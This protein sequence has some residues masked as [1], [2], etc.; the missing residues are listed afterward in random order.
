MYV[1]MFQYSNGTPG[2]I[3]TKFGTHDYICIYTDHPFLASNPDWEMNCELYELPPQKEIAHDINLRVALVGLIYG[4]NTIQK[5]NTPAWNLS[6]ADKPV[7][8][9]T[10]TELQRLFYKR[11]TEDNSNTKLETFESK[12]CNL[13]S[14]LLPFGAFPDCLSSLSYNMVDNCKLRSW[15]L[16]AIF[17]DSLLYQLQVSLCCQWRDCLQNRDI[18]SCVISL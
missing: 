7:L 3:S 6:T 18:P 5:R 14:K 11:N 4:P 10:P 15:C 9:A 1:C 8:L 16:A 12:Q 2:A 17:W 13:N